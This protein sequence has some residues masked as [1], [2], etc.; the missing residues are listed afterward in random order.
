MC[1][2]HVQVGSQLHSLR[3]QK[4]C[5]LALLFGMAMTTLMVAM[6]E[7]ALLES[8]KYL[9]LQLFFD[10][11]ASSSRV[12]TQVELRSVLSSDVV[13]MVLQGV[14]LVLG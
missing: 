2:V 4:V 11:K 12:V 14:S 7:V 10:R 1:A 5:W 13:S 3:T 8:M 6:G 9:L